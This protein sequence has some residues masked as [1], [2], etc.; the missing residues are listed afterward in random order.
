MNDKKINNLPKRIWLLFF[1]LYATQY[2]G[3]SFLSVALVLILRKNGASLDKLSLI[4][5]MSLPIA[6]KVLWAPFIDKYLKTVTG[7]YRNWLLAAQFMMMACLLVIAFIDPVRQFSLVL[8]VILFFS[9]T[10]ATQDLAL[11]GLICNIFEEHERYLISSVKS[12]GS[13]FGNIIGGGAVLL[14]YP[15]IDW[16]GCMLLLA[17]ILAFTWLQLWFFNEYQ[18]GRDKGISEASDKNYWK[19]IISVWKEKKSWCVL[20]VIIPFGILPSYNLMSPALIDSGWSLPE[21][22][23]LL[24]LFGSIISLVAIFFGMRLLKKLSRKQS[25]SFSI[26]FHTCCLL[27]FI[28]ISLGYNSA[29]QVY[30]SF[31][32]YF[33]S[34]PF[35]FISISTIIMD[36][37]ADTVAPAT[38]Y[39]T[40][41]A[42]GFVFGFIV[43]S[44][45]FYL[46]Q[47]LGY[48]VVT[49]GSILIAFLAALL[50]IRAVQN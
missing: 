3:I 23:I 42:I 44:L 28:P 30:S 4:P 6:F 22:A 14:L 1:S 18:F 35:V 45:S 9:F 29:V 20:L 39:N 11:S 49:T 43:V 13:M 24:K 25:L 21:I 8:S 38:A 5:L 26:L 33:I 47:T 48:F 17:L 50:A 10:T 12:S 40:Q 32:L 2:I 15:H 41:T 19:N 37:V 31:F 46:A 16:K 7:H 27:S 34:L 36:N